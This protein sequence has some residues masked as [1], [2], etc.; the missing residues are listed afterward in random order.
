M[1][2]LQY[3][4]SSNC[5]F[6]P[7]HHFFHINWNV[8]RLLGKLKLKNDY[9]KSTVYKQSLKLESTEL[10]SPLY[11]VYWLLRHC[12]CLYRN[13]ASILHKLA[14]GIRT[15][16]CQKDK[17]DLLPSV[18]SPYNYFMRSENYHAAGDF[19]KIIG[20]LSLIRH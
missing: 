4:S 15:H 2:L 8:H 5:I 14:T 13:A 18:L 10:I 20:D 3:I 9:E 1:P 16:I 6:F 11:P 17:A 12:Y 7:F 19:L